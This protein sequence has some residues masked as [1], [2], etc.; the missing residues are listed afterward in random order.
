MAGL[1]ERQ[2]DSEGAETE[3]R[4]FICWFIS[5]MTTVAGVEPDRYQGSWNFIWIPP[6]QMS[7]IQGV[8][9]LPRHI[10]SQL[11]RK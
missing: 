1:F 8:M 4:S 2:N 3:T 11:D 6:T 7:T 10:G 5:Q 9:P